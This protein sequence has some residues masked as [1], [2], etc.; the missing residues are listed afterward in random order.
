MFTELQIVSEGN[1]SPQM[2]NDKKNKNKITNKNFHFLK[3][4]IKRKSSTDIFL[5]QD[6]D[7]KK[8]QGYHVL[9]GFQLIF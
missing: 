5:L 8:A 1:I 4:K 7:R 6:Q 3:D 9:W 2:Q